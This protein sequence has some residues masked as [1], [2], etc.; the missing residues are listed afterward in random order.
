MKLRIVIEPD[1]DVYVAYCP[2]LPGCVTYGNTMEEARENF[3][4]ALE[5]YLRPSDD[6]VSTN[7]VVF[8][9]SV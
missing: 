5:L 1:D 2:E 4:E 6:Q 9:V 8:E 3:M 7:A